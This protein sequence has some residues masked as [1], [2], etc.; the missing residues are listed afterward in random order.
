MLRLLVDIL[1]PIQGVQM[2]LGVGLD[3]GGGIGDGVGGG[4]VGVWE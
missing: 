4:G 3:G 2:V 1:P